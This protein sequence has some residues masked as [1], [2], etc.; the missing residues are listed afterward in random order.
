MLVRHACSESKVL[1]WPE[2]TMSQPQQLM[3]EQGM[4]LQAAAHSPQKV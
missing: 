1:S 2:P 3:L 4:F